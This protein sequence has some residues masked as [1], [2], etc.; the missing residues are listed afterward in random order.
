MNYEL[1]ERPLFY[2]RPPITDDEF[3]VFEGQ[4]VLIEH[5]SFK[6]LIAMDDYLP[7]GPAY[8]ASYCPGERP[9]QSFW[10]VI[11]RSLEG[12]PYEIVSAGTTMNRAVMFASIKLTDGFMVGERKFKEYLT[13]LDSMDSTFSRQF[14]Y[15]NVCVVCMNTVMQSLSSGVSVGKAKH[16]SNFDAN[17]ERLITDANNFHTVSEGFQ[18][19][20]Q[21]ALTTPCSRDEA[22]AWIAGITGQTAKVMT[23]GMRNKVARI[24]ELFDNGAGNDGRSHLDAFQALTDFY[25]HESTSRKDAGAQWSTSEFGSG[26]V[27]KTLAA[28]KFEENWARFVKHGEHLLLEKKPIA[29]ETNVAPDPLSPRVLADNFDY[30]AEKDFS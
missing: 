6:Q 23:N 26:A 5:P 7:V 1:E 8:S 21:R 10:D 19:M 20:L 27:I 25:T 24:T 16:T 18:E 15:N 4:D 11:S 14:R 13:L 9:V 28:T 30:A 3:E 2:K 12:L 22:R 17:V 29:I